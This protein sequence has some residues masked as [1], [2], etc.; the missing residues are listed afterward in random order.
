MSWIDPA[1]G[2]TLWGVLFWSCLI[3][4]V[5]WV[6]VE[7]PSAAKS[8]REQSQ[9]TQSEGREG[10]SAPDDDGMGMRAGKAGEDHGS[11]AAPIG[12]LPTL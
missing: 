6:A 2:S 3:G 7:L 4:L 11:R 12:D 10:G 1:W 9:A 5:A 8:F